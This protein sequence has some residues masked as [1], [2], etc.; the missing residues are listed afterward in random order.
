MNRCY[1]VFYEKHQEDLAHYFRTLYHIIKL[2]KFSEVIVKAEDKRRYTSL[3][4]A[5]LSAFELALLF[6]NGISKQGEGFRPWI[7]EFGL[8]EHLDERYLLHPLHEGLYSE[9]AYK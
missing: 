5:Q 3:A 7:E 4:R 1:D 8:L 9:K 6:Y 2:V